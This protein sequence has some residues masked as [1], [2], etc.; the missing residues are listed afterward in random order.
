MGREIAWA[1]RNPIRF[2]LG[3]HKALLGGILG[4]AES[5]VGRSY[6]SDHS[7]PLVTEKE[8]TEQASP[9]EQAARR[10][11][12]PGIATHV[13]HRGFFLFPREYTRVH[14]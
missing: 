6:S 5:T 10:G 7:F 13:S 3:P 9:G 4:R 1:A 2:G 12:N 14:V 8:R 11:F